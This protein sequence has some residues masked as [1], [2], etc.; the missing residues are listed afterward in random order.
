MRRE[1]RFRRARK[2]VAKAGPDR[3]VVL[4]PV[5]SKLDGLAG[6]DDGAQQASRGGQRVQADIIRVLAPSPQ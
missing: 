5:P 2:A 6:R 4:F 1:A 3:D